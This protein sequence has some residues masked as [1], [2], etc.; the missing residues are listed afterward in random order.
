MPTKWPLARV[1]EVYPGKDDV[2]RVVQVKTSTGTYTR[3]VSKI[4]CLL[5]FER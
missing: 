3:P 1:T 2:V 5:P 4:A